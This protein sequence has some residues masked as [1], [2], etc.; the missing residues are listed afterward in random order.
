MSGGATPGRPGRDPKRRGAATPKPAG[1][2]HAARPPAD[3]D[4]VYGIHAVRSLLEAAPGR[5]RR[6]WVGDGRRGAPPLTALLKAAGAAQVPVERVP[7]AALDRVAPGV[8]Q[9]VAAQCHAIAPTTE[10]ALEQRWNA[11]EEPFLL[12]LEGVQDPRNLGACLRTADAAG[13]DAVLLH[14]RNAA[15]LSGAAAKAASGALERLA[16]VSVAN[17][18]RRIDWLKA[19]GV[20][21]VGADA[22]ADTSLFDTDLPF[23]TAIVLGGEGQGLRRLTRERC[24]RL[25]R[26]PMAGA[27]ASL[28]VAVAAG[29]LLFEAARRR[30]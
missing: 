13:V 11:L 29:V 5:V 9:G 18:A 12:I 10:K 20:W 1:D 2:G 16:I 21:I 19:H 14:R 6:L 23:P 22:K 28:N 24:D 30:R 15:A 4:W 17:V 27:V 7:R 25:V 8:H 26:I 3:E